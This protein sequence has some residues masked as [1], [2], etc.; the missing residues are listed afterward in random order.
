MPQVTD[1]MAAAAYNRF[2]N[3]INETEPCDRCEGRGYHHGHGNSGRDPDWCDKCGGDGFAQKY[4]EQ[5]AM[6][7]ALKAA[8]E[9][10]ED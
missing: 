4:D 7:L 8:L 10:H 6:K 3:A 9:P 1:A 2:V 5:T